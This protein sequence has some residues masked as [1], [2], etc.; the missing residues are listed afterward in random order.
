[1]GMKKSWHIICEHVW[2]HQQSSF[3][4][5]CTKSAH[6]RFFWDCC[7]QTTDQNIPVC[8]HLADD[9]D[10]GEP[11][12]EA[13]ACAILD[14]NHV[15]RARVTLP[16]GD[17]TNTPQVSTASHH[18]QVSWRGQKVG[19][20]LKDRHMKFWFFIFQEP[21]SSSEERTSIKLDEVC[22][23]A[24]VQVD[25][26]RVVDLDEG[27]WVADGAG[28]MGYQVGDSLGA[29]DD[30][31]HLAQLVLQRKRTKVQDS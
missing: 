25:A 15:E 3:A 10:V 2:M 20:Y 24:G 8:S 5:S 26:D 17:H 22:N 28:V 23:L 4:L 6:S 12:G 13:V 9:E 16:V 31:L 18:A 11:G 30:L 14:V 29:N 21:Q 7:V 27:V 1:M 19:S